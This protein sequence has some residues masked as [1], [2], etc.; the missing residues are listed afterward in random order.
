M[1]REARIALA[2]E[3]VATVAAEGPDGEAVEEAAAA[4]AAA[5]AEDAGADLPPS[6]VDVTPKVFLM[7][8]FS[9]AADLAELLAALTLADCNLSD[10][11]FLSCVMRLTSDIMAM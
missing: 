10:I 7:G 2:V 5:A 4:A 3:F 9:E 11:S 8:F 1:E 6:M